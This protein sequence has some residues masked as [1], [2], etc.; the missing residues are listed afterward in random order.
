VISLSEPSLAGNADAYVR[1]AVASTFVANGPY[2][3]RFEDEF[4]AR[5]GSSHAVA[6]A[7]GTAAIH[8]ALH[9]LGI[10]PGDDVWVSDLTFVA[11]ANPARYCGARVVLVDSERE[12]WNLDP[13]VVAGELARRARSGA[14]MP[15]AIVV[16]HLLGHPARLAP[17]VEAA[18]RH[19]IPVVEDAAESLGATWTSHAEPSVA[20]R[21]AGTVGTV[22]CYSF[23][24]NKIMTTGGGGMVVT[25]DAALA[26]R[27]RHLATQA[28]LPGV[29]YA[30]DEI[31]FN[32]RM[33][34]LSAALG[35]AQLEQLDG[36]L[37]RRRAIADRYDR[38]FAGVDGVTVPPDCTWARRSGWLSSVMF[39]DELGRER[40]RLAL[41]DA[42]IESRPVWAPLRTQT[43]YR[44]VPVLG[45]DAAVRIAQRVLNVP[46]SATLT[47]EQQDR[48]IQVVR[49]AVRS[50][51]T[52]T[53]GVN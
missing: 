14:A 6:C 22:G 4:A 20:G 52:P 15:A 47:D 19:G 26:A 33:S 12:S 21:E 35:T 40:V 2:V 37:A 38:A 41:L 45:G 46:S 50:R 5:V 29:G 32:Y 3:T 28:K 48:V 30:H 34:N 31:G 43:P 11:S 36:F 23:N 8:L 13:D 9:A 49:D 1:D 16:V 53:L 25:G 24:G 44:D 27:V 18:A 42:A 39:E 7:S 51:F 10:G 17:I